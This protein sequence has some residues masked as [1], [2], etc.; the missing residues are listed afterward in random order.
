MRSRGCRP[1]PASVGGLRQHAGPLRLPESEGGRAPSPVN[2][3]K[4]GTAVGG[5]LFLRNRF[6]EAA[7]RWGCWPL[8]KFGMTWDCRCGVPYPLRLSRVPT[9]ERRLLRQLE[10]PSAPGFIGKVSC[11]SPR[12][13]ARSRGPCRPPRAH[14]GP[15]QA[16][17]T[18]CPHW[19][20]VRGWQ[21]DAFESGPFSWPC[22]RSVT[23]PVT[24]AQDEV[25]LGPAHSG[26]SLTE[27][28]P[29][30]RRRP[31]CA[32]LRGPGRGGGQT[33]SGTSRRRLSPPAFL[34]CQRALLRKAG[35]G[36]RW[37]GGHCR[38]PRA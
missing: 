19:G 5:L 30:D 27:H 4:V 33:E 17:H 24:C 18:P 16:T 6:L 23:G 7:L 11:C 26:F 28:L 9:L 32:G 14:P 31:S 3:S 1:S 8:V 2:C 13:N 36:G 22:S 25:C 29:S 21:Q 34:A 38:P 37:R 35:S 15:P 12:E 20:Q 10:G